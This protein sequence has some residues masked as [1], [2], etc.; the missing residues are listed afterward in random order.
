M[1]LNAN[2]LNLVSQVLARYRKKKTRAMICI[3][4]PGPVHTA[5]LRQQVWLLVVLLG[6]QLLYNI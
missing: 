5:C 6:S 3:R 2:D 1:K 4:L